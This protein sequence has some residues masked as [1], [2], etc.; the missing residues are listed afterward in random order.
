MKSAGKVLSVLSLYTAGRPVWSPER[1]ARKLNVSLATGYRYFNTLVA[2]GMLERLQ[3]NRYVLGP[4][5]VELDRQIRA[6]DPVLK[7]ARPVMVRL[8]KRV[9]QPA[10]VLLCRYF[11]QQVM[12]IHEETN[13]AD[14]AVSSYERG[15]RRPL[16]RGATSKVILAHLPPRALAEI[17]QDH[18]RDIA[19]AGHGESFERIQG[20]DAGACARAGI[21]TG[22]GEVD[23]GRIGIAAPLFDSHGRIAAASPSCCNRRARARSSMSRLKAALVNAARE[24]ERM[25]DGNALPKSGVRKGSRPCV[26]D[27]DSAQPL[28]GGDRRRRPDRAHARQ[29]ARHVRHRMPAD[30]A[31]CRD[32]AGAARG[33]DRRRI[34]CARCRPRASPTKSSRRPSRATARIILP[35]T[36]SA[37]PRS[38]RPG[39]LT[40]FRA[41]MPSASR[42]WS[43]NCARRCRAFPM[44]PRPSSTNCCRSSR[45]TMASRCWSGEPDGSDVGIT[46]DYLIGCDGAS[47]GV[48]KA[49]GIALGGST[50]AERWLIVDLENSPTQ[51]APY[52]RVLQRGAALY[53]LA[54][55]GQDPPLRILSASARARRGFPAIPTPCSI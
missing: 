53:R 24:I 23:P 46:C 44:S 1:A 27:P 10:T 4:A 15:A 47:S 38:S 28:S 49:L 20:L 26:S 34:A 43:G 29:S 8:L 3:R 45:T 16:I 32:R 2:S 22:F 13:Q 48:R 40:A 25:R 50:F 37:S 54:G 55:P 11:R 12:C 33:L 42:S 19:A 14:H 30:R 9:R 41:A 7:I 21:A 6:A 36:A 51:F 35:P 39:S 17:W 18:R 31:A 52:R 5:I